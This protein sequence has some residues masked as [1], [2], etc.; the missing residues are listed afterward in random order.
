[1]A[2]RASSR[3]L[4]AVVVGLISLESDH[5]ACAFVAV[6][7]LRSTTGGGTAHLATFLGH[8]EPHA[9]NGDHEPERRS[10]AK[11]RER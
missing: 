11:L 5:S 6:S 3:A 9:A 2:R 7:P 10:R 4:L 1:M 8:A